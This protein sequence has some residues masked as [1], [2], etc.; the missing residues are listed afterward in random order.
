VLAILYISPLAAFPNQT[1]C[2][3]DTLAHL[4]GQV[5]YCCKSVNKAIQYGT[6]FH[7]CSTVCTKCKCMHPL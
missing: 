1:G 4:D 6:T 5:D 3:N 7:I 2:G